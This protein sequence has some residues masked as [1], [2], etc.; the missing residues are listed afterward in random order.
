MLLGQLLGDCRVMVGTP[1]AAAAQTDLDGAVIDM[2]TNQ[3]NT[4]A[5]LAHLGD[6]T[7]GSVL[8]LKL[9][10]SDSADGSSPSVDAATT[11]LTAGA[12]DC[13]DKVIALVVIRPS[14]RY[15]F[16]R[17]SRTTQDAA[18]NSMLYVVG[19]AKSL[20]VTQS[21]DVVASKTAVVN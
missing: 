6:V 14:K 12:S 18:V 16:G 20:P 9:M 10:A 15:V 13:D 5:A 4:I 11:A 2:A 17:L 3:S 21:S 8:T 19:D 7:S 1:D